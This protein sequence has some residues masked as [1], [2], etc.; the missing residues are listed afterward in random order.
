[1]RE[2]APDQEELVLDV[3]QPL[4][5]GVAPRRAGRPCPVQRARDAERR[6]ELVDV[7]VGGDAQVGLAHAFARDEP[8][9]AAVAGARVAPGRSEACGGE[10]LVPEDGRARGACL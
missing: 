5:D 9:L 3:L 10:G 8:R 1:A 6:V 2:V 4:L 7:A